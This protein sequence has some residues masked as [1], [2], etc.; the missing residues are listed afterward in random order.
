M[1][2]HPS[3]AEV[4]KAVDCLGLD[5]IEPRPVPVLPSVA[6]MK[7][8]GR[9]V[10]A[11]CLSTQAGATYGFLDPNTAERLGQALL[12]LAQQARSGL[13]VVE[14]GAGGRIDTSRLLKGAPR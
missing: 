1:A 2:E 3:V 6:V 14:G 5:V 13:S 10:V 7:T 11:I 8:G 4:P 12:Q 9:D